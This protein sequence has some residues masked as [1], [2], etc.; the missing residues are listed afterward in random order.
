M[1][2]VSLIAVVLAGIVAAFDHNWV[3]LRALVTIILPLIAMLWLCRRGHVST[4]VFILAI[5]LLLLS[6]VLATL[7]QGIHDVTNFVYPGILLVSSL[8]LNKR[9]FIILTV[10]S[11]LCVAWLVLG[12]MFGLFT[13]LP[14]DVGTPADLLIV[15]VILIATAIC[16]YLL[17]HDLQQSLL[18]AQRQ[19]MERQQV[20]RALRE[21]QTM[22]QLIFDN[23]L[24]GISVYE[25]DLVNNTRRLIDCNARYAELAGR[26]K[27]E[28][29][30]MGDTTPVQRDAEKFKDRAEFLE[31]LNQGV[32][33][34]HFSWLR[35]DGRENVI[36]YAAV[37]LHLGDR[38]LVIGVDRDIT[39]E[40]HA[41][42]EREAMIAALEAKN[43]ELERFT[44]TVSHDLKSPLI[45][46]KGFVGFLEKDIAAGNLER[47]REDM[48]F[49]ND[50]V[51][52]MERL[53]SE[54][55]ELSRI[56]RLMNPPEETPFAEIAR[57]AVALVQGRIAERGVQVEIAPN[58]PNVYGDRARLVEVVQNLVDNACKFMGTQPQPR[59][60]IGARQEQ[61]KVIFFV[62]DN[63]IGVEPSYHERIFELFDKLDP[64][65]EG[66]GIGL[67]LVKRIV[68]THGGTVWVESAGAGQGSTFCFT[69]PDA[70]RKTF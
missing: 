64:T 22:L 20:E 65:T 56:G 8:V 61:D 33:I 9:A 16:V 10:L 19:M 14:P 5:S 40:L 62:R 25:E 26:T 47:V 28:L 39:A 55:L 27:E 35:P 67:A 63:G 59:I 52:K 44:Y 23:A 60:E 24:D 66:T 70:R 54:L 45:T 37:P 6:T 18:E 3:A 4:A 15:F 13:P 68:E 32:Y 42:A 57:E 34:G 29:L 51:A 48:A 30:A 1:G 69:L 46:V 49:I 11:L 53:L 17:S 43:A 2:F 21:S 12:A 36:E 50:A 31:R 38:R 58:L 41:Q 7:G